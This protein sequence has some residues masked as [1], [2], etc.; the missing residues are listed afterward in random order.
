MCLASLNL[1][2]A[3]RGPRDYSR[4]ILVKFSNLAAHHGHLGAFPKY[5]SSAT[6]P[7]PITVTLQL[8]Y[9]DPV[10]LEMGQ[11]PGCLAVMQMTRLGREKL[12]WGSSLLCRCWC[13]RSGTQTAQIYTQ[14][15]T[16]RWNN[17][18]SRSHS[19]ATFLG[20]ALNHVSCWHPGIYVKSKDPL[21][22]RCQ[23]WVCNCAGPT[24][25][26]YH[27]CCPG[28]LMQKPEV[29]F[30]CW[31]SWGNS[32]FCS[33]YPSGLWAVQGRGWVSSSLHPPTEEKSNQKNNAWWMREWINK[34]TWGA[35]VW[36]VN[37]NMN[38][39]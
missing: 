37:L 8:P 24:H 17:L 19:Q 22:Q 15:V 35:Q 13:M 21:V 31:Y 38:I 27:T 11:K 9:F 6:T 10:S 30:I 7:K 26:T 14:A 29:A 3:G 33:S 39:T 23:L 34:S 16:G 5:P 36:G 28:E 2:R 32:G 18:E 12:V 1:H 4:F 25:D 20:R